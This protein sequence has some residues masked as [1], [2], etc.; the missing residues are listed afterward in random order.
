MAGDAADRVAGGLSDCS[1]LPAVFHFSH[2]T[3]A[4]WWAVAVA[5]GLA[6]LGSAR[7]FCLGCSATDPWGGVA[8]YPLAGDNAYCC[9][10]PAFACD[11]RF[12]R[13]SAADFE[14]L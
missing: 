3:F 11:W 6:D 7:Q 1:Q 10:C 2:R 4:G 8:R 13:F 14:C 5:T 12:G 9:Q